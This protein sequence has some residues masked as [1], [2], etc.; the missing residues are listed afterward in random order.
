MFAPVMFECAI[1][2]KKYDARLFRTAMIYEGNFSL[3]EQ[4]AAEIRKVNSPAIEA[5]G[6]EETPAD[7]ATKPN[8]AQRI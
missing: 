2:G 5:P 1:D 7:Q 3:F 4:I 8:E 6:N